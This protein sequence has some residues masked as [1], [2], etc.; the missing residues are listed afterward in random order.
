MTASGACSAV[1]AVADFDAVH[2][3]AGR[4]NMEGEA[5]DAAIQ[6]P[7]R[8][9]ADFINPLTGLIIETDGD[10]GIGLEEAGRAQMQHQ[11]AQTHRQGVV[12]AKHDFLLAFEHGLVLGQE[13]GGDDMQ[14]R[15]R[16]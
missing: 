11:I 16:G 10:I 8:G 14:L 1:R 5:A 4:G 13:I 7:D 3:P 12:V 2:R 9:G 6:V 15:Q